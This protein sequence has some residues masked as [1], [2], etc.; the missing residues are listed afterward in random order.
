[1][2]LVSVL[3]CK[4]GLHLSTMLQAQRRAAAC[5]QGEDAAPGPSLGMR[6]IV[7]LSWDAELLRRWGAGMLPGEA[8]S[9][10]V[11]E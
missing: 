11:L 1:M 9:S 10:R 4:P 2:P 3:Q 6:G 5:G 7:D 8:F